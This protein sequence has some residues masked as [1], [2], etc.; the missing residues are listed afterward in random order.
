M[1][2]PM[3][4]EPWRPPGARGSCRHEQRGGAGAAI[5]TALRRAVAEGFDVLVV[6]AGN[7]KD[8][9]AEI[10]RLLQPIADDR[11]DIVQ[12]SRYLPGSHFG[13]TPFYRQIATRYVHPLLFS[14]L[15]GRRFT[16]TTNGFRAIRLSVLQDRRID[17]DQAW[18]NQYQLELVPALQGGPSRVSRDGSA[19]DE[20]LPAAR[21]RIHE[22][23]A[24]HGL[25][26]HPSS[27]VP[28][29]VRHQEMSLSP[30]TDDLRQSR[31]RLPEDLRQ[32]RRQ[33]LPDARR[34]DRLP[35]T[36]SGQN[37]RLST[38]RMLNAT[39]TGATTRTAAPG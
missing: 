24:D 1:R 5:R 25:V 17:L 37:H 23:E 31:R 34:T 33:Q 32:D 21:T 4:R 39:A 14:V 15:V 12:G 22:D 27:A 36:T 2:Q 28:A 26:E 8:R 16:D 35:R 9:P 13:N 6:L 30:A 19:G 3:R 20:D 11:A 38:M 10:E 18:L 7:D 29:G